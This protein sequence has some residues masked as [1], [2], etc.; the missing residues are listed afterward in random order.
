MDHMDSKPRL[1]D[2]AEE[3]ILQRIRSGELPAGS[4]LPSEPELAQ[5]M[6]ISRGILREALN[7]LQTRGYIT[8]TP[9]GGSHISHPEASALSENLMK[10]F[11][12]A[13]LFELINF[14]EALETHA[15]M[16]VIRMASDEEIA[17]LRE[18]ADY[19]AWAG[20]NDARVFH[21]R[22]ME[23][24]RL[25]QNAQFIDFYFERFKTLADPAILQ[26]RPRFLSNDIERI[27]QALEKRN[28]HTTRTTLER[29]FKHIRQW[30]HL[31]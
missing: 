9:R 8:R 13:T 18:L 27:L 22:L 30:H 10:G 5:Q 3:E 1:S 15:A 20:I 12:T 19:E 7:S 4:R 16:I 2:L 11:M 29:H 31:T 24:S 26:R 25:P 23:L 14:R 28:P 21:Y 6:G 17:H